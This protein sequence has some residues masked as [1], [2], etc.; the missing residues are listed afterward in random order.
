MTARYG[1]RAAL[2]T[3]AAKPFRP[4]TLPLRF[5]TKIE[6]DQVL[7]H[8]DTVGEPIPK[9][10]PRTSKARIRESDG[11]LIQGH[12]YTPEQTRSAEDAWRWT[13]MDARRLDQ[14]IPHP[15]GVLAYFRSAYSRSDGDN[16]FKLVADAMNG[17][18]LADDVQI[19]EHHIHVLHRCTE[20]GTD[21]LV[22]LTDR[23]IPG[24]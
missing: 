20:P 6:P 11:A 24:G 3:K 12:T 18:I 15:V 7:L 13:M 5:I 22:W 17:T 4:G 8:I 23:R 21:L 2:S 19:V 10:R 9:G 1:P 16:L 14:A